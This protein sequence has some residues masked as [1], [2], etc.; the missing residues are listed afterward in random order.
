MLSL[1]AQAAEE[2]DIDYSTDVTAADTAAAAGLFA[3]LGIFM[4]VM[5]II[6]LLFFIFNVW[7]LIDCATRK[8]A[9]FP[10]NN[11]SLWLILLIVGIPFGFGGLVALIYFFA[12][13]RKAPKSAQPQAPTQA[14]QQ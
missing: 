2:Y 6:G 3:G 11:K 12:V 1:I 10:S 9:D 8:D 4:L 13:K 5:V 14:P 7:M